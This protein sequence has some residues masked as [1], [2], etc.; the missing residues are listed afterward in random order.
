MQT[1]EA[2]VRNASSQV[3]TALSDAKMLTSRHLTHLPSLHTQ[4]RHFLSLIL[5]L[6][7]QTTNSAAANTSEL[8]CGLAP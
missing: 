1:V 5:L 6:Y 2:L 3:A 8:I 4:S 7:V